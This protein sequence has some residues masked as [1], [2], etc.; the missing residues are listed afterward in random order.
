MQFSLKIFLVASLI[1]TGCNNATRNH[2]TTQIYANALKVLTIPERYKATSTEKVVPIEK[3]NISEIN[4][5][6]FPTEKA[7]DVARLKIKYNELYGIAKINEQFAITVLK[8]ADEEINKA[9][10]RINKL[11]GLNESWWNRNKMTIGVVGG[12]VVGVSLSGLVVWGAFKL[13]NK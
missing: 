1:L 12:F 7:A 8:V 5:I 13:S 4:G 10:A 9:D 6:V 2:N 3:G 11:Q